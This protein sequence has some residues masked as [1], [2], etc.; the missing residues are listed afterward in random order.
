[1]TDDCSAVN[2]AQQNQ[3]GVVG[4]ESLE[5]GDALERDGYFQTA[6]L[7]MTRTDGL[8][9][10]TLFLPPQPLPRPLDGLPCPRAAAPALLALVIEIVWQRYG[11]SQSRARTAPEPEPEP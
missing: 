11:R 1:M 8:N 6:G 10:M 2:T 3:K 9:K 4:P 7:C 5:C